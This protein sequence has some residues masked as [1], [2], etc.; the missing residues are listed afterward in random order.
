MEDPDS[1]VVMMFISHCPDP[2][3]ALSFQL[4]ASEEWTAAEVQNKLD[5]YM[6]KERRS[7][8]LSHNPVRLANPCGDPNPPVPHLAPLLHKP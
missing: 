4:K 5:S 6:R 2:G 3:L 1:E 8:V 7:Y